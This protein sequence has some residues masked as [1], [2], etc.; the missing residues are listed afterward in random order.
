MNEG[1]KMSSHFNLLRTSATPDAKTV[2]DGFS[3]ALVERRLYTLVISDQVPNLCA[4][5]GSSLVRLLRDQS[6]ELFND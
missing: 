1:R 5:P 4:T 3:G 2:S 6:G